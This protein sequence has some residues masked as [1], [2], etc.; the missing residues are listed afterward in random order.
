MRGHRRLPNGHN[1]A[2]D[3]PFGEDELGQKLGPMS[4]GKR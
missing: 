2:S 3:S 4:I 1:S